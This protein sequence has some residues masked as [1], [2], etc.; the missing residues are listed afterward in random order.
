MAL[1]VIA[2]PIGHPDDFSLRGLEILRNAELIIGEEMK[3][4][5][6]IM[7]SAR[8]QGTT[9][10]QLNEHSREADI[11]HFVE[12]CKNKTV[13][14]VSDCGTP[15]FCDPGADLVAAC[16][17]QGI[18]VHSVP[19]ASSL[20]A[21]L[22]IAGVRVDR[23]LF[24]GF[25]PAKNELRT[26]A[27]SELKKMRH[28]FIVMETPYRAQTLL[29]DLATHFA[30]VKCVVGVNLTT[31]NEKVLRGMGRD[32]GSQAPAGDF[33]PIALVVPN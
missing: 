9:L 22:S 12:Q 7:K 13:A 2:T 5:R 28:P 33:E 20:M 23:F 26:Q 4:L 16:V 17:K 15:G 8:I 3:A 31:E 14:L 21:L 11:E 25:L 10:D 18:A 6:Q 32:L 30:N 24:Y 19:G 27:W 29:S 1:Y